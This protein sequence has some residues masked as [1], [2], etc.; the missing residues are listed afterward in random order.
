MAMNDSFNRKI[1]YLRISVTDR[2]N[3]R[4]LYCMPEEG[5]KRISHEEVLRYE[6]I[7]EIVKTAAE[8]GIKKVR[9]TGG[10]PLVRPGLSGLI[11]KIADI[12]GIES[13]ALTTN[14]LLLPDMA[15]ELANAGLNRVNIS[16]DTLDPESYRR[17]SR[18][19]RIEKVFEGIEAAVSAGLSPVKINTVIIRGFND[20]EVLSM[21]EWALRNALNLRFIEFMP[22]NDSTFPFAD[23]YLSSDEIRKTLLSGF[24][25]MEGGLLEGNGPAECWKVPGRKGSLGVIEA[26]SHAFC[27]SCNRLRLTADGRMR[28][29][30]FS[31]KEI[32]LLSVL[33]DPG[34]NKSELSALISHAV[35][36]KPE[37]HGNLKSEK[38]EGR[39]MY[40]IGG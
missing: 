3:L 20:N 7:I 6:E 10:E 12:D 32:N 35:D 24:P 23:G 33:R 22:V 39:F 27:G 26:V 9:L 28:P 34:D 1:D 31:D 30:L 5:V 15:E 19:G 40:E 21:A 4:C 38:H 29:C 11:S 17:M 25:K 36:L 14:G 13:I 16:L 8:L 37:S 2:C 18:V